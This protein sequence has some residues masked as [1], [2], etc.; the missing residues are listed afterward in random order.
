VLRRRRFRRPR[1][2]EQPDGINLHIQSPAQL[3]TP[4]SALTGLDIASLGYSENL[5]WMA[6]SLM[7]TCLPDRPLHG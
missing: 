3:P 4:S 2:V 7:R 1:M 5:G 6:G